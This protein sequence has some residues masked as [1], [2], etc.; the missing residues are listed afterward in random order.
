M[1]TEQLSQGL[2]IPGNPTHA[3]AQT[4]SFNS[5]SIDL[6]KFRRCLFVLDVGAV[7]GTSPTLDAKLHCFQQLMDEDPNVESPWTIYHASLGRKIFK[8][9]SP[10]A[11]QQGAS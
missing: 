10:G 11:G 9:R 7:T 3:A 4:A 1:Y 8:G 2:S 5:N 6:Q